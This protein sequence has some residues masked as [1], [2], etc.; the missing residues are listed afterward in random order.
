MFDKNNYPTV[1]IGPHCN[2]NNLISGPLFMG[3]FLAFVAISLVMIK[4][5][6][7]HKMHMITSFFIALVSFIQ[8]AS[9]LIVALRN[10]GIA[11]I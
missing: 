5:T 9:F 2:N 11:N 8:L 3:A 4:F 10:P 7:D 1:V 6:I